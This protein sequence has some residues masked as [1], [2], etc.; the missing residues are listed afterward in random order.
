MNTTV[1]LVDQFDNPIGTMEKLAAH[2]SPK[3]HR[4]FSIFI[5]HENK[6]LIQQRAYEKYHGGGLWANTCCSHPK[7]DESLEAATQRRL[8]EEVGI[9]T[10][11]EEIYS[12]IYYYKFSNGLFEY[13]YDHV[14]IG[15]YNGPT[16][17]NEEEIY[18]LKWVDASELL[19]DLLAAPEKY[20][21]WFL[22]AAPR[23]IQHISKI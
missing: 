21:P 3:L 8:L 2:E 4:A 20:A 11:L 9:K 12:F 18:T 16:F 10:E 13:E 19:K 23:V 5:Y 6:L 1:I 14:F 22:A 7:S 17:P 15:N